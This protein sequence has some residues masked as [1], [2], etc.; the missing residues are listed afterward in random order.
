MNLL[1]RVFKLLTGIRS[2]LDI[3]ANPH[4]R[5]AASFRTFDLSIHDL[6]LFFHEGSN[7]VDF[8]LIKGITKVSLGRRFYRFETWKTGWILLSP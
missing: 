2:P 1:L 3:P 8:G 6:N 7:F 4:Y 5:D